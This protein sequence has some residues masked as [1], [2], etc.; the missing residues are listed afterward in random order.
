MEFTPS[1][2]LPGCSIKG[3]PLNVHEKF[4]SPGMGL[5]SRLRVDRLKLS[6]SLI[7][8]DG[9]ILYSGG[10]VHVLNAIK[11][12]TMMSINTIVRKQTEPST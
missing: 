5:A 9:S 4:P 1:S 11:L 10:S 8:K 2:I 3:C 12:L 6:P 7:V